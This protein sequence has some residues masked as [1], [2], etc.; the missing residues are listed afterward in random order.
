MLEVNLSGFV[1][2]SPSPTRLQG[3]LK[4]PAWCVSVGLHPGVKRAEACLG[5]AGNT[6]MKFS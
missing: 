1:S 4:R 6:T 2:R 5:S 3:R